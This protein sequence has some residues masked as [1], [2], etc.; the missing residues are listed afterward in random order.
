M[1]DFCLKSFNRRVAFTKGLTA[2]DYKVLCMLMD[3][4]KGGVVYS[5]FG[6][7]CLGNLI[8]ITKQAV[9]RSF[10]NLRRLNLI[11][12]SIAG[13]ELQVRHPD[14]RLKGEK[15]MFSEKISDNQAIQ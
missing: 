12:N 2:T 6:Q 7:T 3:L 1:H 8:G 10:H 11:T 14:E 4:E 5:K 13:I 15:E 9:N